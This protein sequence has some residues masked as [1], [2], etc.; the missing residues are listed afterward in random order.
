M[1]KEPMFFKTAPVTVS[2]RV[3]KKILNTIKAMAKENRRSVN[4]EMVAILQKC[5]N[6]D[7]LDDLPVETVSPEAEE[8]TSGKS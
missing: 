6:I 2:L 5:L 7:N 4:Q 8:G 3:P 1:P